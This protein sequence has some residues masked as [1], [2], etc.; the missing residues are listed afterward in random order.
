MTWEV[1]VERYKREGMSEGVK[2]YI[3]NVAEGYPFPTNLDRRVPET[4]GMAPESEQDLLVKGLR[5]GWD[6]GRVLSELNGMREQ[7]FA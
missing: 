7:G 6:K 2:T 5:E 1:L 4:A 3:G